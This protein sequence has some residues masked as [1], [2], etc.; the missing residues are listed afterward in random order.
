MQS[1]APAMPAHGR[2]DGPVALPQDDADASGGR[3]RAPILLAAGDPGARIIA[4]SP[5]E[6]GLPPRFRA[7]A[8]V[9]AATPAAL[10]APLAWKL[11]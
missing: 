6:V 8:A 10:A 3:R 4:V 9:V 2:G 1:T 5:A 11:R 7:M